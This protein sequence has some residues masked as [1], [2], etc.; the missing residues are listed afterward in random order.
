M[1][2]L[3]EKR[4]ERDKEKINFCEKY[5]VKC[6]QVNGRLSVYID[7]QNKTIDEIAKIIAKIN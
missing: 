1:K 6:T 4:Q 2:T 7:I 3:H 5:N